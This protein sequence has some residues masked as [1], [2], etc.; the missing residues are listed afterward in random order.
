ME[1]LIRNAEMRDVRDFAYIL[2]ESWKA[3]YKDIITP[4]ELDKKTNIDERIQSLEKVICEGA[5]NFYIAFDG[6]VPCGI[7]IF[8]NSRD[9]DMNGY[10]EIIAI[11]TLENYWGKGIGEK[12]IKFTLSEIENQGFNKVFLWAFEQNTRARRFYEKQGFIFDGSYKE[13]RFAKAKEV[14]YQRRQTV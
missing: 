3:A 8:G 14:R 13:S 4:E 12:L 9:E 2:C 11:Y 7:V 5:N 10:A 1:I 6:T